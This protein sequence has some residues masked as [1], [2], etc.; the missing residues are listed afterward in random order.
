VDHAHELLR[1][2]GYHRDG[3]HFINVNRAGAEAMHVSTI[4]T[5]VQAALIVAGTTPPAAA[6]PQAQAV[7]APL[8][9]KQAND[10]WIGA[11]IER[12]DMRSVY[13]RGL[14][15]GERAHGITATPSQQ[16]E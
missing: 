2:K 13:L 1:R 10:L 5:I 14:R 4:A 6:T 9:W 15:D 16:G 12:T 7:R 8:T 3:D 11:T